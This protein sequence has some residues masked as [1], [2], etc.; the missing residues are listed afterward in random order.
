MDGLEVGGMRLTVHD[1]WKSTAA[2]RSSPHAEPAQ[3]KIHQ[4]RAAA[5]TPP[6]TKHLSGVNRMSRKQ[7]DIVFSGGAAVLAIVMLVFGIVMASQQSF[8][9]DYVKTEL[10]AQKITFATDEELA[11]D[12]KN[13]PGNAVLDWK[14]GSVC[15][16]EN[17]G[18]AMTTGKQAE[19]YAK[20]YI[21]MHMARSA[22][23]QKFSAP[24]TVKIGGNEQTLT[25][26]EGQTYATIGTIRT[27]LAADQKA[28]AEAGNKAAADARQKDVDAAAS[29]R[30][31]MQ[32]GETLRGLL[33][34]T[35]GFS[36]FGDKAGLASSVSYAAAV[37]LAIIAIA[38]FAHA[39]FEWRRT[40]TV[41]AGA[42]VSAS[43][44]PR[45]EAR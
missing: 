9:K 13:N 19:C 23:N 37:V 3:Q 5:R 16:S 34:T 45:A 15:L 39:Y 21:G 42:A 32:T 33:L 17:A 41:T 22:V 6:D 25:T 36:T 38:G 1:S 2:G 11:T 27:A 35:F 18:K 31:T 10:A 14:A 28:L 24:I 7:L 30:T 8:A 44:A 29:L 20:Y 26:M 40:R 43:N 12:A 4:R